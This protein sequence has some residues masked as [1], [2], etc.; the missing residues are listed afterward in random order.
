MVWFCNDCFN[1]NVLLHH[2]QENLCSE[3][4]TFKCWFKYRFCENTFPHV[5][6]GN[7][8]PGW[9]DIWW[10]RSKSEVTKDES[11]PAMLHWNRAWFP[12]LPK[13]ELSGDIDTFDDSCW[14]LGGKILISIVDGVAGNTGAGGLGRIFTGPRGFEWGY[15]GA[16]WPARTQEGHL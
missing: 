15:P 6:H 7:T 4:T 5:R 13:K 9:T 8:S 1:E 10:R 11:Q 14:L 12:G 2:T 3:W 16:T